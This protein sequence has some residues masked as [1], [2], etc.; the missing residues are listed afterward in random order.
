MQ[1]ADSLNLM[2]G[3]FDE[4][5]EAI[6]NQIDQKYREPPKKR[7]IHNGYSFKS[8]VNSLQFKFNAGL[9]DDIEDILDD[10]NL[11]GSTVEALNVI[12]SKISKRHKLIKIADCSPSRWA[13]ITKYEDEPFD[14][15]S[16]AS[17][18]IRQAE[19]R[20]LAKNKN[21]SPFTSSSKPDRTR[22]PQFQNDSFQHGC[23]PPAPPFP[24]FFPPFKPENPPFTQS[25]E[26]ILKPTDTCYCCRPT[27][28]WH[29]RCSK[30]NQNRN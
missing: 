3:Y 8:K 6:Q 18:K 29:S 20:A 11:Q 1:P 23:N 14:S 9:Q 13:T 22:R 10:Q 30:T 28:H 16:E 15:D 4:N 12:V 24:F 26:K 21:K 27:G 19:N 2:F 5:F 7:A 17:K 25:Q